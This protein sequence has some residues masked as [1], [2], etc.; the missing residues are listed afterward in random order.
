MLAE[1]KTL[2]R[3]ETDLDWFYTQSGR[4][5]KE[6]PDEFLAIKEKKIIAKGKTMDEV[7]QRLKEK[8]EDPSEVLIKFASTIPM[9]F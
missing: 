6:H 2:N 4:L 9:I 7:V 3:L 1:T 8:K 5:K